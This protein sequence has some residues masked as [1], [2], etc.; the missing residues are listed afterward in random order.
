MI[1]GDTNKP[2]GLSHHDDT[3]ISEHFQQKSEWSPAR[4]CL[5]LERIAMQLLQTVMAAVPLTVSQ[6]A[7]LRAAAAAGEVAVKAPSKRAGKAAEQLPPAVVPV[8]PD[9]SRPLWQR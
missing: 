6:A 9:R 4:E 2:V 1:C 5:H 3:R 7:D 8:Q